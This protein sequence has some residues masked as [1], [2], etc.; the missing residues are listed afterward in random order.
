M[1]GGAP[2]CAQP[3]MHG[4]SFAR[5]RPEAELL[6]LTSV[7]EL[8]GLMPT[9]MMGIGFGVTLERTHPRIQIKYTLRRLVIRKVLSTRIW[10]V[11]PA[12]LGSR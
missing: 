5:K 6:R 8:V 2:S 4:K 9:S 12:C 11:P 1:S 7:G 3:G 10:E